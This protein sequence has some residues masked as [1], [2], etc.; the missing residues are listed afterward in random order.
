MGKMESCFMVDFKILQMCSCPLCERILHPW[1][2]NV[3][4]GPELLML[5]L[6][7]RVPKQSHDLLWPMK[8]RQKRKFS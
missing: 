5:L 1:S 4:L 7:L 3:R 2:T 8:C 6:H